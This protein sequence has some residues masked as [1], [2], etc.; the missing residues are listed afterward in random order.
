MAFIDVHN[1][2][3]K[4]CNWVKSTDKTLVSVKLFCLKTMNQPSIPVG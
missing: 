1:N 3:P 4:P 2:D